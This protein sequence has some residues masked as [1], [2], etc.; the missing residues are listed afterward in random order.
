MSDE[1]RSGEGI[2][3][4]AAVDVSSREA[5]DPDGEK[6]ADGSSAMSYC[7][8]LPLLPRLLIQHNALFT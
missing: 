2:N 1:L 3:V 7:T 5:R 4:Q 6:I 8:L